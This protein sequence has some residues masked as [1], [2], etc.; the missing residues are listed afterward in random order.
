MKKEVRVG[1][2]QPNNVSKSM[3]KKLS[4]IKRIKS[5]KKA[6]KLS[7]SNKKQKSIS[8]KI[9]SKCAEIKMDK[10]SNKSLLHRIIKENKELNLA[11]VGYPSCVVDRKT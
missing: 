2:S 11:S 7:W 9:S 6:S 10:L 4:G 8:K 1:N 3:P 5:I